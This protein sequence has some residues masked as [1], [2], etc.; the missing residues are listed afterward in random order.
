MKTLLLILIPSMA[1]AAGQKSRYRYPRG[2]DDE[3]QNI[4]S[5]IPE[6]ATTPSI[7]QSVGAPTFVPDKVGDIDINTTNG[8]V[9]ISTSSATSGSWVLI[10]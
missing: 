1:L 4:Y 5:I 2:L 6:K 8:K 10:N 7:Y 9:Y 3:M